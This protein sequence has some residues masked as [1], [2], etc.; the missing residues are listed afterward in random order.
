MLKIRYIDTSCTGFAEAICGD[1]IDCGSAE[2]IMHVYRLGSPGVRF[3]MRNESVNLENVWVR[4]EIPLWLI[5]GR[6]CLA[7]RTRAE[8]LL[9]AETSGLTG[10]VSACVS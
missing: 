5:Y 9:Y 8:R 6:P 3:Q 7:G 4:K 1:D 10:L 2:G